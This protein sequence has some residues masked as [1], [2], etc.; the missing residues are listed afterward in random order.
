MNPDIHF[1]HEAISRD[2][3]DIVHVGAIRAPNSRY[4]PFAYAMEPVLDDLGG[5]SYGAPNLKFLTIVEGD[6]PVLISCPH[7]GVGKNE[8]LKQR[9]STGYDRR[10]KEFALVL[11]HLMKKY[12]GVK[13]WIIAND[14]HRKYI[15]MNRGPDEI[16]KDAPYADSVLR[17][18]HEFYHGFI[19]D[20]LRGFVDENGSGL[21]INLHTWGILKQKPYKYKDLYGVRKEMMHMDDPNA[22]IIDLPADLAEQ[23]NC[24]VILGTHLRTTIDKERSIDFKIRDALLDAGI[25]AYAPAEDSYDT[26]LGGRHEIKHALAFATEDAHPID[27]I[28]FEAHVKTYFMRL[29]WLM[30]ATME[31][32]RQT[33]GLYVDV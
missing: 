15:D 20:T 28:Q 1:T 2:L 30:Y 17:P 24:E 16:G 23:L 11:A 5:S 19:H 21:H 26:I 18:L 10:S 9:K 33:V 12:F 7:G 14:V 22:D 4:D 32:L 27:S 3:A 31:A 6:I 29:D 13:P 25:R 8:M